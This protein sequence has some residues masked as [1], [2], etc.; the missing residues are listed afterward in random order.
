MLSGIEKK[1]FIGMTDS[2]Y[3]AKHSFERHVLWAKGQPPLTDLDIE[4]TER[5]NNACLHCYINLPA[6]DAKAQALELTAAEWQALLRQA[7]NLGVL[8]LRITGGEPLLRQDFTE[9]YTFARRLGMKVRLFTNARCITPE[10]ADLFVR[11]PP[12]EKIEI[13]VYGMH[14]EFYDAAACAPGGY[15]EFHRGV[16]LL[17]ERGVPF[18]VKGALLPPNRSE[19][20]ELEAW[21]ASLPWMEDP[22]GFTMNFEL[23]SRRDSQTRNRLIQSLRL[24]PD[25]T[26][27]IL[28]KEVRLT[29]RKCASSVGGS[30]DRRARPSL[31]AGQVSL[32]PSTLTASCSPVCCCE[33]LTRL[34]TCVRPACRR[35]LK[36]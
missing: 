21:A 25:E 9:I 13:T 8:N 2:E 24:F 3:V 23:R 28:E 4:L 12:L 20:E 35:R 11:I 19:K 15:A 27:D 18:I 26:V 34:M 30:L 7:A 29:G 5:C 31:A 22:L 33:T 10:V 32:L 36:K 6:N 17:L 14:P 1:G 16:E